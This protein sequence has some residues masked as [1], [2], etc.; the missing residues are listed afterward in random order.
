MDAPPPSLERKPSIDSEPKT[1][2]EHEMKLAREAA[3]QII[4]TH[5]REEALQIFLAGLAP[6]VTIPKQVAEEV[7]ASDDGDEA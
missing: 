1:L 5:T 7:V 3:V 6:P 2:F 4:N